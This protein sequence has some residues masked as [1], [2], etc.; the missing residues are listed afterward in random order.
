[1][2]HRLLLS[3]ALSLSACATSTPE[4]SLGSEVVRDATYDAP[5]VEIAEEDAPWR[6]VADDDP[7]AL[8]LETYLGLEGCVDADRKRVF[9]S[10]GAE[11]LVFLER[12][13]DCE[14]GDRATL[15]VTYAVAAQAT[16]VASHVEYCPLDARAA[17]PIDVLDDGTIVDGRMDAEPAAL[18][19]ELTEQE[20]GPMALIPQP[21][22]RADAEL[23]YGAPRREASPYDPFQD[24]HPA[25]ELPGF[26]L[27]PIPEPPAP[28]PEASDEPPPAP[29]TDTPPDARPCLAP[30][31]GDSA[32]WQPPPE[33]PDEE[34]VYE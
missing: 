20:R 2:N 14:N 33:C 28:A 12:D 18:L 23:T 31:G 22:Y 6:Q 9:E 5:I 16:W 13:L 3:L 27:E 24:G 25:A 11:H 26:D 30:P 15:V 17:V 29:D 7:G 10:H 34:P 1:M 21:A 19:P 8:E 4:G 32:A